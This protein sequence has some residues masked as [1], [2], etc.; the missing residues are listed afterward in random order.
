MQKSLFL[1]LQCVVNETNNAHDQTIDKLIKC[2]LGELFL[3]QEYSLLHS[4]KVRCV[5]NPLNRK[6]E[7]RWAGAQMTFNMGQQTRQL[8]TNNQTKYH[9]DTPSE[10]LDQTIETQAS[11]STPFSSEAQPVT[12]L[13]TSLSGEFCFTCAHV[14][15]SF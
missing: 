11:E 13:C 5:Q 2:F 14:H 8:S 6:E 12:K 15:R 10:Y 7:N 1:Y 3:C 4:S 9:R